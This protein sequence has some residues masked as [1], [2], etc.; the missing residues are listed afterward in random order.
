[1]GQNPNRTPREHPNPTT[2]T[3]T[4]MGGEFAYPKMVPLV[5]AHSH[6]G[7]SQ[8][9]TIRGPHI[10]VHVSIYQGKPF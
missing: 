2:K 5:L 3:G 4:K 8:N 10:L 1:M 7:M 9:Y 6:M